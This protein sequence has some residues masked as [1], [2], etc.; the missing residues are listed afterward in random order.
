MGAF[1]YDNLLYPATAN[2][3]IDVDGLL[4]NAA[5]MEINIWGNSPGII[6][7][8]TTAPATMACS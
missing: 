8:T 3:Q 5:G 2:P 4:F 1:Y 7:T 6:R